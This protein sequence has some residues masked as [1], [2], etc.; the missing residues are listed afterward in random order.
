MSDR[1]LQR[2]SREVAEDPGA[3]SFIR[4]ARAYRRQG[5]REAARDVV[6]RG[7]ESNPE[8]VDAHSLL[9][10]IHVEEGERERARDEWETVLTLEPGHFDA[11]RGLGFLALE[12][13]DLE[14]ARRHLD[15]AGRARP[16]DTTVAQ[17][18]QLLDRRLAESR[19]AL[20]VGT[21]APRP[22]GGEASPPD[23]TGERRDPRRLFE[24]LR[25]EGPFLGALALDEQGLVLAGELEGERED[26][27]ELLGGLLSA[28]V[29]EARRTVEL[30]GMEEWEGLVV[31]SEQVTFHLSPLGSGILVVATPPRTPAGWVLRVA[32]L[33]RRAAVA[34]M[35]ASR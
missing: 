16:D 17:A 8:H 13:N 2:W 31:E 29:D 24:A 6:V 14:R 20:A 12:R 33:A 27:S 34:F 32:A 26:S 21:A 25:S 7:L 4:L 23:P 9:A 22:Q 10:L 15:A 11:S 28:V 5:R 1:D 3:P 35:E 19:A 30:V 18:R